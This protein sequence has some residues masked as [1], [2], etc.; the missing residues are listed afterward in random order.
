[1]TQPTKT[2]QL[3][4]FLL[5]LTPDQR[6]T[7]GYLAESWPASQS[8]GKAIATQIE[9]IGTVEQAISPTTPQSDPLQSF[10]ESITIFTN[11]FD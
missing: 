2:Q 10:A 4:K 8:I 5:S 3:T 6:K 1:M 11:D 7:L 9:V